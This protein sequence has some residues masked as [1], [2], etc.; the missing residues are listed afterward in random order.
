MKIALIATVFNEGKDI[1]RWAEALRKQTRQ[2]DEFVVVDG[3]STDGTAERLRQE[4]SHGDFTPPRIIIKKCNIARGR[5]LAIQNTT[6]EIVVST[7]AGSYPEPEWLEE[8]TRPLR[9]TPDIDA[10]GGK[11][12]IVAENDF[13]RFIIFM[14]GQPKED[15]GYYPSSRNIALR[16][17]AWASVGGYPEWLTLAGED[18]LYNF[19][20]HAAGN[21]FTCNNRA[22]VRW[23]SRPTPEAFYQLLYRNGYGAAESPVV[24]PVFFKTVANHAVSTPF[25]PV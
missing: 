15:D 25:A 6:A 23:A 12:K 5:N 22:V 2:P 24:S 1:R 3:G 16:R 8:L 18:A 20:L 11:T 10:V 19:E 9:E 7:D 13:Q 21:R 17:T 4:F 14:E